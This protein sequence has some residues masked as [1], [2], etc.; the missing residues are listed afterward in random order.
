MIWNR[1]Y[2]NRAVCLYY[3]TNKKNFVS[4]VE[5]WIKQNKMDFLGIPSCLGFGLHAESYRS[6]NWEMDT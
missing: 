2:G 4:A 6:E 3:K 1:E 5:K